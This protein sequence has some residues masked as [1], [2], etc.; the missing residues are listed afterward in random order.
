MGR[1]SSG[2]RLNG[3][4]LI[5]K[6]NRQIDQ[7]K[8]GESF[9]KISNAL[10]DNIQKNLVLSKAMEDDIKNGGRHGIT[11]EWTTGLSRDTAKIKVIT[12]AVDGKIEYTIKQKNKILLRTGSKEQVANKVAQFYIDRRK[13]MEG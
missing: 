8:T 3:D 10:R 9:R 1:G 2:A 6:A 13:K 4:A 11:D 7:S 12:K 5:S